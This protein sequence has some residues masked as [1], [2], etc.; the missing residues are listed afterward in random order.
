MHDYAMMYMY[1]SVLIVDICS[2]LDEQLTDIYTAILPSHNERGEGVLSKLMIT[3]VSQI[4]YRRG[5]S[6]S[7]STLC[8]QK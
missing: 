7:D 5:A 6:S 1:L 4:F 2:V 8:I 3:H